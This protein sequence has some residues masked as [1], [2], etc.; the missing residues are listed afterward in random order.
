MTAITATAARTAIYQLI[1]RV[2]SSHEPVQIT[3]KHGNAVM[4]AEGDWHAIQETLCLLSV[5]GMRESIVEG[6]RT[7]VAKC[8]QRL[9]W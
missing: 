7:P 3:S 8:S 5:P 4:L 6:I 1:G 2:S 9:R